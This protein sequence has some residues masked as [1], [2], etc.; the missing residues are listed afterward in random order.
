MYIYLVIRL[1]KYDPVKNDLKTKRIDNDD[2]GTKRNKR[3]NKMSFNAR[4]KSEWVVLTI[5]EVL[6]QVNW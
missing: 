6:R 2:K 1:R 3:T 4:R 5:V